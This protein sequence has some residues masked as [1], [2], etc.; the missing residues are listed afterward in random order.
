MLIIAIVIKI[1]I[2]SRCQLFGIRV[3]LDS[4]LGPE[5]NYPKVF[6]GVSRLL[7]VNFGAVSTL[8]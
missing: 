7:S 6:C 3:V 8:N 4:Y 1:I 5:A 2:K